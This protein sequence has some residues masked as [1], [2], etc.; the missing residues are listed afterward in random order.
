MYTSS[1]MAYDDDN[2]EDD[3]GAD[4]DNSKNECP[5]KACI[6]LLNKQI[7]ISGPGGRQE[8]QAKSWPL[9]L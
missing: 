6:S 2:D 4:N 7:I 5:R 8:A 3:G 9:Q 1:K